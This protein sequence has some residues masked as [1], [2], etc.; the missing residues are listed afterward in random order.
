MSIIDFYPATVVTISKVNP[1]RNNE[2]SGPAA[3]FGGLKQS[4]LGREGG[5]AGIYEFLETKYIDVEI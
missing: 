4:G 5:F 1:I 3:P 2:V